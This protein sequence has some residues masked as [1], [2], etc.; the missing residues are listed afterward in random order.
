[1][2][3]WPLHPTENYSQPEERKK[4]DQQVVDNARSRFTVWNRN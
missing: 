3:S 1:M 4:L 2:A